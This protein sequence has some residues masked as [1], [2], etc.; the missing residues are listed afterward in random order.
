V[1]LMDEP[2]AALDA[3]P[4]LEMQEELVSIWQRFGGT[5][6]LR[7]AQRR[8]GVDLATHVP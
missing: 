1:I 4:K 6:R 5:N 8:R 2:F 7:H 3:Q